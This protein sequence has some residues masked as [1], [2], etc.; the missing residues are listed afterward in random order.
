M[1]FNVDFNVCEFQHIPALRHYQS[2]VEGGDG[3]SPTLAAMNRR[4]RGEEQP[5]D[6]GHAAARQRIMNCIADTAISK[7]ALGRI[8][9]A[10]EGNGDSSDDEPERLHVR[11]EVKHRFPMTPHG[12]VLQVME[13]PAVRAA[14]PLKID[15]VPAPA[16]LHWLGLKLPGLYDLFRTIA[17][18]GPS[19]K[20]IIYNDGATGGNFLDVDL[21]KK[22]EVFFWS[23]EQF[24]EGRLADF[25]KGNYSKTALI[26]GRA[27]AGSI[28]RNQKQLMLM[29]RS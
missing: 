24:G 29:E 7:S 21:S 23:V 28:R 14:A 15:F 6:Q 17:G 8:L 19:V 26:L 3:E 4:P 11:R 22:C 25:T 18:G 1:S 12:E 27:A 20:L 16:Y 13:L 10:F 9:A 2:R 5:R